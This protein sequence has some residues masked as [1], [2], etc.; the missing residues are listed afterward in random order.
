MNLKQPLQKD[1]L[2]YVWKSN[3]LK[4][5]TVKGKA[6]TI[7]ARA[8][9]EGSRKLRITK[10]LENRHIEVARLSALQTGRLYPP[11]DTTGTHFC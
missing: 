3:F 4:K 10:F 5:T 6:I 2:C 8:G 11:G 1:M 7:Q 9:P